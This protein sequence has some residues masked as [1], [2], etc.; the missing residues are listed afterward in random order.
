MPT[1][2][3]TAPAKR[4]RPKKEE[5]RRLTRLVYNLKSYTGEPWT[6]DIDPVLTV[7]V[8]PPGSGKSTAAMALAFAHTGMVPDVVYRRTGEFSSA[9]GILGSLGAPGHDLFA[10]AEYSDGSSVSARMTW[11]NGKWSRPVLSL[12]AWAT[13]AWNEVTQRGNP[14]AANHVHAMLSGPQERCQAEMLFDYLPV[15]DLEG[16]RTRLLAGKPCP[17]DANGAPIPAD[18]DD[19]TGTAC[20]LD[21]NR[22]GLL[23]QL[24]AMHEQI[25]KDASQR[26]KNAES[27]ISSYGTVFTMSERDETDREAAIKVAREGFSMRKMV[28]DYYD[29]DKKQG[30]YIAAH[31]ARTTE[32][33][34]AKKALEGLPVGDGPDPALVAAIIKAAEFNLQVSEDVGGPG[35]DCIVC[36]AATEPK[37]LL[38]QL[39]QLRAI[40]L[41]DPSIREAAIRASAEAEARF[42]QSRELVESTARELARQA[43][44]IKDAGLDLKHYS[45]AA[46]IEDPVELATQLRTWR[47]VKQ[48]RI[49]LD[50][51]KTTLA[52]H[53]DIVAKLKTFE[54]QDYRDSLAAFEADVNK[55]LPAPDYADQGRAFRVVLETNS[56]PAFELGLQSEG[57]EQPF[58]AISMTE[59]VQCIWAIAMAQHNPKTYGL[60][61]PVMDFAITEGR[62]STWVSMLRENLAARGLQAIL[63]S[64]VAPDGRTTKGCTVLNFE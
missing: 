63:T 32:A 56:R 50:Q 51:A 52:K 60:L 47:S 25:V 58:M 38:D 62:L 64:A 8:G 6:L 35:S 34:N 46:V 48:L 27:R 44:A 59:A 54:Q 11:K 16:I 37:K 40:E 1:D 26:A 19:E 4:G 14:L 57:V 18:Q 23:N 9:P 29:L 61:L 55:Y 49:E 21:S 31:S 28:Q 10:I 12:P 17:Q 39:G 15:Y 7:I 20:G 41:P 22:R 36:G 24:I 3:A 2:E 43:Q 42:K 5:P 45:L 13:A 33:F 53:Q 30:D